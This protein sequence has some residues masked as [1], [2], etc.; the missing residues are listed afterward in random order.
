MKGKMIV[1]KFFLANLFIAC[2]VVYAAQSLWW[3]TY[4]NHWIQFSYS[5]QKTVWF[6]Q[7]GVIVFAAIKGAQGQFLWQGK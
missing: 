7:L 5:A 2:V 3:H 1:M 6:F 4:D